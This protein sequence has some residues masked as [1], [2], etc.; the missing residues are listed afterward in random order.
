MLST[1]WAAAKFVMSAKFLLGAAAGAA[2]GARWH[3]KLSQA[4]DKVQNKLRE[5]RRPKAP[6]APKEEAPAPAAPAE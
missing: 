5:W 6:E 3:E 1:M 4:L 2:A